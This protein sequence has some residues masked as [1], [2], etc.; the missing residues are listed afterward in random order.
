M[1]NLE[2]IMDAIAQ[3][4]KAKDSTIFNLEADLSVERSCHDREIKEVERRK[5]DIQNLRKDIEDIKKRLNRATQ[6]RDRFE[7]D[8]L[9][10]V[11]SRETLEHDL[12]IA[13]LDL[14]EARESRKKLLEI[15]ANKTK[16]TTKVKNINKILLGIK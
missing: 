4:L 2:I 3:G 9:E 16:W 14:E 8:R 15:M 12:N 10:C 13:N 5:E 6:Q 1:D 7:A 11:N